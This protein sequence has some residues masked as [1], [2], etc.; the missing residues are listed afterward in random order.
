MALRTILEPASVGTERQ[1]MVFDTLSF[2]KP[3]DLVDAAKIRVGAA[4]D[5]SY[6]IADDSRS[7]RPVMSFGVG[8][9]VS[10]EMGMAERGHDVLL[11]DH[12]ID[13]LPGVH[14]RFTWFKE[15]IAGVSAAEQRLF[16]LAEHI[17]KLPPDCRASVL[18]LDVEGEEWNV[19]ERAT[20]EILLRFDQIVFELHGLDQIEKASFNL[21]ART[22]L[23]KLASH[24][25]LCHVHANNFGSVRI[26][27]DSFP[28]PETLELSYVRSDLVSR[29]PSKT[30]YPT[31]IDMPNY[32]EFPEVLL[33]FY[34]FLPGSPIRFPGR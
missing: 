29:V 18:K 25:T 8:P 7:R 32:Q 14:P 6:V 31:P 23:E 24:F 28:V 26:I 17:N 4:G 9:S 3:F 16:S 10:F 1:R 33:W 15:G 30:T 20:P 22:I 21:R 34:P 2:L 11:F 19:F 13:A 27:C 5:G 12:T